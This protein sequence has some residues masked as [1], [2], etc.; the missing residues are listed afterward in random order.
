MTNWRSLAV[1]VLAAALCAAFT[2]PALSSGTA[3]GEPS[4]GQTIILC[5]EDGKTEEALSDSQSLGLQLDK[6]L[7]GGMLLM[8]APPGIDAAMLEKLPDVSWAEPD[9]PFY[10]AETPNDP[11]YPRQWNLQKINMPSAWDI[12]G[13]G[14]SSVVIAVVDSGVAYRD[15]GTFSKAPDFAQTS[16]APGYDFIANDADPDDEYGHGTHVAAIIASSYNNGFRAAGIASACTIMPVRV[17]GSDGVGTASAVASGI[18]LAADNGARVICLSL[19]SPRHSAAVGEAVKYASSRGALC[20]AA[21]GNEGSDPG[22]PGGMDCPADEGGYVLAV[23]ATDF[24]DVRAHYSNYGTGLDLVAPGGDLTRDDNHDGYGDGIPQESYIQPGKPQSGYGLIWGEG[25]SMAAPQV[26]AAAGLLLSEDPKLTP[27]DLT[28]LLTST[29]VD[30]GTPGLDSYYGY[31]RLNVAAALSGIGQNTWYFAEGTTRA[32]FEEW[33]CVLNP[34]GAEAQVEFTFLMTG[35]QTQQATFTVPASSRF[36]LNVASIVGQDKDVAAIISSPRSIFAERAMYFNYQGRWPGGSDAKGSR[37]PSDNWYFAEGTTRAGFE[38][39]LTLANPGY[40]DTVAHVAYLLGP[41]QG[42]N[43]T[44]DWNVPALSRVTVNV[45]QAVGPEK[46]VSVHVTSGQPIVAERPMYFDYHGSMAG[47]HDV[48]GAVSPSGSWFFA[49]GTTRAGF[50]EWL[51][52]ANPGDVDAAVNVEYL[53]GAGQGQNIL[54]TWNVPARSRV[55]VS[56]NQAVGPGKDVSLAIDSDQPVVAERPMYFNY[57]GN[58]PGGHDVV[59]AVRPG[60]SWYFAEGTTRAGFEE[61]LTL[62]NPGDEN[63]TVEVE[64]LLG[65]G[66]GANVKHSLTVPAFTRITVS[67]NQVLGPGVDVSLHVTSDRPVVAER[68][69]YFTYG[70]QG[71]RGGSC[72]VGYDPVNG[73]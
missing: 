59:G 73:T 47:G 32:G 30:L 36:S 1:L 51:T 64:Y 19:S 48:M 16:F 7:P 49:E 72:E 3:G 2:V 28:H 11:D 54:Q 53:L 50:E 70:P 21:A 38:E 57:R 42:S 63:A 58:I 12:A 62:A 35:G 6:A 52:L 40:K 10:A 66:Q 37:F 26:A 65:A 44:E 33:L 34:E 67:V 46:D 39:W 45:N 69:M 68:P 20:V 4:S 14:Q 71:W 5:P 41:G 43:K 60:F 55:T 13:R 8:Q 61:W 22:Y 9:L 25:T 23:G 31:G 29:C 18:Y 27:E 17:L 15:A 56:V 24:R